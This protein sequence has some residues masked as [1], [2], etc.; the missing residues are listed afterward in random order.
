[1]HSIY[2]DGVRWESL[3]MGPVQREFELARNGDTAV[4][5]DRADNRA[6]TVFAMGVMLA[7]LLMAVTLMVGL[8][9]GACA[10]V[11]VAAG[12]QVDISIVFLA[13]ILL[14]IMPFSLAITLDRRFGA[15]LRRGSLPHRALAGAFRF[16]SFFGFG[17]GNVMAL[18]SSHSG[19]RRTVLLVLAIFMPV[20]LGVLAGVNAM[21]SPERFGGYARF[22]ESGVLAGRGIGDAHYDRRRDVARSPAVPY[23]QDLVATGPYLQL[24]VPFVPGDDDRAM[25]AR[26]TGRAPLQPLDALACLQRIHAVSLDGVPLRDLRYDAGTDP[27]TNRPA[28]VAMV[29]LRALPPGRHELR[30]ARSSADTD[31]DPDWHIPFWR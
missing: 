29:D 25:L 26:C 13:C 8:L 27:R 5:I 6:T 18:L 19:E 10:V 24:T 2:P 15:R 21:K 14:A 4:S 22:P 20:M 16:W 12:L 23:I 1:M 9:F 31:E 17:R 28:L 30:V 3:R 11:I 7:S